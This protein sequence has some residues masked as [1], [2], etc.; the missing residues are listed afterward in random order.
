VLVGK[1][2]FHCGIQIEVQNGLIRA[3][4]PDFDILILIG[5][6]LGTWKQ[7]DLMLCADAGRL[8]PMHTADYRHIALLSAV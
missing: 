5:H 3:G 4:Q 1:Q 6:A 7:H 8:I 2:V